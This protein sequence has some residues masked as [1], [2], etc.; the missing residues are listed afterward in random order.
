MSN[1]F[2]ST[3][4]GLRTSLPHRGDSLSRNPRC[5][6]TRPLPLQS[7]TRH[8]LDASHARRDCLHPAWRRL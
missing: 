7:G 8:L 4:G 1:S 6:G 3:S 5:I 2:R